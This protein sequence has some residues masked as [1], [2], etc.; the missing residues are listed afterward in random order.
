MIEADALILHFNSLQEA[1]QKDGQTHFAG[2]IKKVEEIC[3]NLKVPV[4]AKEVG[5]GFS[6]SDIELLVNAG[7]SAIDI[8]GAGGTSWSQVEMNRTEDDQRRMVAES[9]RDWGIQTAQ[10][11]QNAIHSAPSTPIIA[12]GGLRTGVDI[13][14]YIAQCVIGDGWSF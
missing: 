2:L 10:A 4:I 1:L 3:K 7:V 14:K 13:A 5:W 6:V 12:S 8:A 9:F 11:I